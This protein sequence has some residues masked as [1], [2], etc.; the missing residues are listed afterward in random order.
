MVKFNQ[1]LSGIVLPHDKF[2]SYLNSK[3]EAIDPE[4]AKKNFMHAG[5]I[6][7]EIWPGMIIDSHP[8]L[9]EY[10]NEKAEEEILKKSLEWKSNHI[11]E[12]QYFLQIVKCLNE[13]C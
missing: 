12:S 4:L 10:I 5:K 13:K 1:E 3:G 7:A 6:L 9:A 8:V 2:G 11:R